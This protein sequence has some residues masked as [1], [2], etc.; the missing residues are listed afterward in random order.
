MQN[1]KT[2]LLKGQVTIVP[3]WDKRITYLILKGSYCRLHNDNHIHGWFRQYISTA[4]SL[5]KLT[6]AYPRGAIKSD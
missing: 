5:I 4:I 3:K 2:N 1:G 6:T